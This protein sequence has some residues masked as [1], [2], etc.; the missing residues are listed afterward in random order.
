MKTYKFV[1]KAIEVI[2][3]IAIVIVVLCAIAIV[4]NII[5]TSIN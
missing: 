4:A 3:R 1:M 5:L 2:E